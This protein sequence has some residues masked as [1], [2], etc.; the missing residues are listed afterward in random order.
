MKKH[1]K[2][3]V[4][5]SILV[6]TLIVS[7][8]SFF[9]NS[10]DSSVNQQVIYKVANIEEARLLSETYHIQFINISPSGLAIFET[11][12]QTNM[13]LILDLG[14]AYD[15]KTSIAKPPWQT[16]D[17]DP[18]LN[19]QYALDI[20]DT[21]EAWAITEGNSDVVV[22]IIDTGID[23]THDEF[24]GR[25][26]SI[27]YNASTL[28]VGINEVIDD[29]G[30]GTMVAGIIGAIKDNSKGIAG[31]TSNVQL[32]VIKAN[33]NGEDFFQD[34]AMI[35][36][37]YYAVDHGADIINLSLGNTYANPQTE[38]ALIYAESKGVIVVAASGNDGLEEDFYPAA[39]PT[40]ISVSAID[41]TE[42]IAEYSNFGE[43]IDVSAPGTDIITTVLNN[44]YASVS[45]TSFAAPQVAGVLALML[46]YYPSM[47]SDELIQRLFYSSMDQGDIG[48][49][50]YY[51]HGIVNTYNSLTYQ[52]AYV[53]FETFGGTPIEPILVRYNQT[54][55][56][57]EPPTLTDHIFV[58]WF[59]DQAL[60]NPWNSESDF[61]TGDITL[62]A[63]YN[64]EFHTVNFISEGSQTESI[65]VRHGETF[66]LPES[67][68][69]NH[70]FIE[71]TYDVDHLVPYDM[72]PILS[73]TTLYAHFEEIIY[74]NI[75]LY[76]D[77]LFYENHSLEMNTLFEPD[78]LVKD[79][80]IFSGWFI[81][82][83]L[84]IPYS[85]EDQV[86]E[87]LNLYSDFT[88]IDYQVTF[89]VN[90]E[91]YSTTIVPYGQ[92]PSLPI[93]ELDNNH[94]IGWYFDTDFVNKYNNS[95]MTND[96]TLYA[97]FEAQAY[98]VTYTIDGTSSS[99]W[100]VANQEFIPY[101]PEKVSYD[102][103]GWYLNES[104][105][106]IYEPSLLTEDLSIYAKFTIQNFK[107]SF[108]EADGQ[109]IYQ[110]YVVEAGTSIEAPTGPIKPSTISYNYIFDGWSESTESINSNLDI[111][112]IYTKA[113][114]SGSIQIKPGID[115]IYENQNWING[116]ITELDEFLR[117]EIINLVDNQTPG[118]Y[119]VTYNIYEDQ[120]LIISLVRMVRVIETLTD[121]QITLNPGITTL[122]VGDTYIEASAEINYGELTIISEVD[123]TQPGVYK[124]IY[125]VLYEGLIYEKT[126]LVHV[127]E[128]EI[129][130][131]ETE[132][133]YKKEDDPYVA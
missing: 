38:A 40:T 101:T 19:Q 32:M 121:I 80:H 11:T 72:A 79:G 31:I 86:V 9:N 16:T 71:W 76:V 118:K 124:V 17:E 56:L 111:Y 123:T 48:K 106:D 61:V 131:L 62:Y 8:L 64:S 4:L 92:T 103:M 74:L 43:T 58:G 50:I 14:F 91:I 13:N 3:L 99:E 77:G 28:Q 117:L 25:I 63:K 18:Y 35:E 1:I 51:G 33:A 54:L 5:S 87:N 45:G 22:A 70:R 30:H 47:S 29:H 24:I 120:T 23:I 41:S 68:L 109:T 115:T 129:D 65:I 26:S 49:D 113:F 7:S 90:N 44:G 126:R 2:L 85:S 60:L 75:D 55:T 39:F 37:I 84:T 42:L 122:F 89:M 82:E 46:S 100:L 132:Y 116:G 59:K 53:S 88:P 128:L 57:P 112:P 27:S 67:T 97:R 15:S 21:V 10:N 69:E 81:D 125:Q 66:T 114:I 36:G 93:P 94:F 95:P 6:F 107:V 34:S 130:L 52:F 102:F 96:L 78:T 127:I 20:M 73:D 98:Q 12:D 104:F 110:E 119:K 108:Y 105:T 83:D 133:Y